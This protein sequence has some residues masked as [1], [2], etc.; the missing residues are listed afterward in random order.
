MDKQIKLFKRIREYIP[1]YFI[2]SFILALLS[3]VLNLICKNS[4]AFADF[5]TEKITS[6]IRLVLAKLSGIFPFSLG[7]FAVLVLPALMVFVFVYG[8]RMIKKEEK[9]KY[10]RYLL[11][12]LSVVLT[13]FVLFGTTLSSA[14][15]TTT[16]DK[17][18][19]LE[20]DA[21]SAVELESTARYLHGIIEEEIE[22]ITFLSGSFSVMPYG[23]SELED[24]M[25][26]AYISL[27][28]KYDFIS[29]F[30]SNV[31]PV[32]ASVLLSY[33]HITGVYTF[34]TGEANINID[35]PDY[36]IP[37]T[38]AHEMAHQRGIAREEEANFIAFLACMESDDPYIRYSGAMNVFE[39][40]VSA[41]YSADSELYGN[42]M[43]DT[44]RRLV[45]EMI[46]YNEFYEK[47]EHSK[48]AD[49][50]GAVNDSYLQSQGQQA[51]IRS[52]GLVTDLVVAYW[53]LQ[54]TGAEN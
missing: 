28:K 44:D 9:K 36:T 40:V 53:K 52:Y 8:L 14:Y 41:L 47:Y 51:G 38:Q 48:A 39:Y 19:S 24:K 30:R 11:S 3:L 54:S 26:D 22:N 35:F 10:V 43:K 20:R 4:V 6:V 33:L 13:V 32:V 18:L 42:L 15:H 7:E 29:C 34:Y 31:K 16:V 21:V 17:K 1:G 5:Y 45:G 27:A 23:L 49:I 50:S 2:V 37:Y 46:A 25:N 12:L